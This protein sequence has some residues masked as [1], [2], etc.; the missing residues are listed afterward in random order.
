MGNTQKWLYWRISCEVNGKAYVQKIA[1]DETTLHAHKVFRAL[2]KLGATECTIL[3]V[4][5][6]EVEYRELFPAVY[7]HLLHADILQK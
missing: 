5:V 2:R 3:Q 6:S 7:T 1:D 4:S